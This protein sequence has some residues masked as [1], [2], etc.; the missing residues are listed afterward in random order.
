MSAQRPRGEN[1]GQQDRPA[2]FVDDAQP[3]GA[4]AVAQADA[5]GGIDL[6]DRM[7]L[8]GAAGAVRGGGASAAR[9]AAQAGGD[10]P[11]LQR[12]RGGQAAPAAEAAAELDTD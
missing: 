6:P 1:D 5:L 3:A 10:E 4:S 12:P 11:A 9:G 2:A 8:G 7:R